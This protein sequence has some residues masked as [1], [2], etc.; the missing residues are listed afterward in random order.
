MITIVKSLN[1][2]H[3]LRVEEDQNTRVVENINT[4]SGEEK[5][6]NTQTETKTRIFLNF[7]INN[8]K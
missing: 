3:E 2:E 7:M 4:L 6:K 8:D 1:Y 5:V